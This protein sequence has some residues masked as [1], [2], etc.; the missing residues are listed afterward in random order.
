LLLQRPLSSQQ[1]RLQ[2]VNH[3]K[4]GYFLEKIMHNT[5]LNKFRIQQQ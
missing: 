2:N 1:Q 4:F 3:D 5:I